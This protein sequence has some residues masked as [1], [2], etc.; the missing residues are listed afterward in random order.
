[1]GI[2]R[3][4][5]KNSAYQLGTNLSNK[6]AAL[7]L[8]VYLAAV[9]GPADYGL[10]AWIIGMAIL[11]D[12]F[13]SVGTGN[14]IGKF[15]PDAIAKGRERL[16][17]GYFR[18]LLKVR[19]LGLGLFAIAAFLLA[20]PVAVFVFGK[21]ILANPLRAVAAF[22]VVFN[23]FGYLQALFVSLMRN[24]YVFV[25]SIVSVVLRVGLIVVLVEATGSLYSAVLGYALSLIAGGLILLFLV[26]WKYNY[27]VQP[28]ERVESARVNKYLKYSVLGGFSFVVL[29]NM[30][31]LMVS[32]MLPIE[33][34]G[35]YRIALAWGSVVI[36]MLPIY[37]VF[38]VISA[39]AARGV[40]FLR[41]GFSLFFKYLSALVIPGAFLMAYLAAPLIGFFYSAEYTAS[42]GVLELLASLLALNS[43][44]ILLINLYNVIERPDVYTKIYIGAIV[45]NVILNY[46]LISWYGLIGAAYATVIT[47]GIILALMARFVKKHAG[48][49]LDISHVVKPTVSS[50]VM[51]GAMYLLIPIPDNLLVGVIVA[52]GGGIVYFLVQLLLKGVTIAEIMHLKERILNP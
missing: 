4:F 17:S 34:V 5:T 7:F 41:D 49:G 20:E 21:V 14:A 35:F 26:L 39:L 3:Q 27:Y 43:I 10:Y 9:L 37:L 19:G 22:L 32:A 51:F 15:L 2:A 18:Y 11:F 23:A 47:Y 6:L 1:M 50:V 8:A 44:T 48:F 16:A 25:A 31:L 52:V 46:L 28:G 42:V 13:A 12:V 33:N 38:P 24:E 29:T 30:D 36:G 45:V 40:N